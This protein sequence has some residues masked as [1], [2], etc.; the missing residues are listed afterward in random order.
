MFKKFNA[1]KKVTIEGAAEPNN[2][3]AAIA[4]GTAKKKGESNTF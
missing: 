4:A 2:I 1:T 3:L